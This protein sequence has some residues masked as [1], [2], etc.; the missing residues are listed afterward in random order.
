MLWTPLNA[1]DFLS[2]GLAIV[3]ADASRRHAC[4]TE[5]R[6]FN[7]HFGIEPAVVAILW[8]KLVPQ[9]RNGNCI[10][11]RVM[12]PYLKPKHLL[13]CLL[14]LKSYATFDIIACQVGADEKTVRK[15]VWLVVLWISDMQDDVVSRFDGVFVLRKRV[16]SP[17]PPS[18]RPDQM[19]QSVRGRCRCL[20]PCYG[21]R[22]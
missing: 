8:S 14:F 22:N 2:L 7:A 18:L 11:D 3:M 4:K 15:W 1:D 21:R 20:L 12:A 16:L 19:E 13:W 9:V 6:R 17:I 10:A 5:A